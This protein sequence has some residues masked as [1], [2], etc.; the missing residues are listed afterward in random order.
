[1][2]NQVYYFHLPDELTA[3]ITVNFDNEL[4]TPSIGVF[5]SGEASQIVDDYRLDEI[6][7]TR[8]AHQPSSVR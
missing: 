3:V 6:P 4:V 8:L 5:P 7:V 1:M 2:Y